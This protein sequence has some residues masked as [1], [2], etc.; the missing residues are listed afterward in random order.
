MLTLHTAITKQIGRLTGETVSGQ[1][2]SIGLLVTFSEEWAEYSRYAVFCK[3]G[4]SEK[5]LL[6]ANDFCLFPNAFLADE[7]DVE[8]GFIGEKTDTSGKKIQYVSKPIILRIRPGTVTDAPSG[9][10]S[11]TPMMI[12]Q[13][14]S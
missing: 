12:L 8:I 14:G 2:N 1:V 10:N 13:N 9:E 5:V 3:G 4:L 11:L 6:D 7:G